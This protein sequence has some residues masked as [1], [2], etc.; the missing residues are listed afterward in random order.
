MK[1]EFPKII[2]DIERKKKNKNIGTPLV[3]IIS[4]DLYDD[5]G[6]EKKEYTIYLSPKLDGD[7]FI[8]TMLLRVQEYIS[9]NYN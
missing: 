6:E 5:S 2:R 7:P 3:S 1:M 9:K 8:K 4:R